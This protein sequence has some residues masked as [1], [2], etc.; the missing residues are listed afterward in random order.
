MKRKV[1]MRVMEACLVKLKIEAL[2]RMER[3]LEEEGLEGF[4]L[5][6]NGESIIDELAEVEE[7]F[8]NLEPVLPCEDGTRAGSLVSV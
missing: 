5:I 1:V 8:E 6:M 7:W 3:T 2:L 4:K